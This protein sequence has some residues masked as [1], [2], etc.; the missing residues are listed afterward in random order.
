[1]C[2]GGNCSNVTA[3][4]YY[5]VTATNYAE[6]NS[7]TGEYPFYNVTGFI[8]QTCPDMSTGQTCTAQ[9]NVFASAEPNST[10]FFS[11][12]FS[13]TNTAI[14]TN[15]SQFN[16]SILLTPCAENWY[17]T[18]FVLNESSDT[19]NR[20]CVDLHLCG[21]EL[22]KPETGRVNPSHFTMFLM[23][24]GL[25]FVLTALSAVFSSAA[26]AAAA[27]T[28]FIVTGAILLKY[29]SLSL[30]GWGLGVTCSVLFLIGV[31]KILS[32]VGGDD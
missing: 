13:S 15:S 27:G 28:V 21:T 18:P 6:V 19:E 7:T 16:V 29:N 31:C 11:I 32:L 5:N 8:N 10:W 4:I 14:L 3:T 1:M 25:A 24:L 17:C 12:N 2:V 20:S 26:L 23:I 9:W 30:P 22:L